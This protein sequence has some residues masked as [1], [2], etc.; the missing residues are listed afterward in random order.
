MDADYSYAGMIEFLGYASNHGL[1]KAPTARSYRV[2]SE[3]LQGELTEQEANDVRQIDLDLVFQ[4]FVNR[5]KV[6]ASPKTLKVYK[7]RVG[8]SMSEFLAWRAD[9]THYRPTIGSRKSRA[10]KPS[11]NTDAPRD[12]ARASDRAEGTVV[13]STQSQPA[14]GMLTIPFPLRPDFVVSIQVPRDL[15]LREADRL[16]AFVRTLAVNFGEED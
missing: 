16:A 12:T 11:T 9:P 8:K 13:H 6:Q 7:Q 14:A 10:D 4:R 2:A 1:M 5:N 15:K 3:R